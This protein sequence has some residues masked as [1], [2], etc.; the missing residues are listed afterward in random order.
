M[1]ACLMQ[2]ARYADVPTCI[3]CEPGSRT[4]GVAS[5]AEGNRRTLLSLLCLA[6]LCDYIICHAELGCEHTQMRNNCPE[7]RDG[8]T[9]DRDP[10][11]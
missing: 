8:R 10:R 9:Y 3:L 11:Q 2:F 4:A 5:T 6:L 1:N 7:T